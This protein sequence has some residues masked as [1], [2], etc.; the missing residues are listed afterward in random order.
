ML[1]LNKR[2]RYLEAEAYLLEVPKFTTKNTVEDTRHF[3]D[4]LGN[5]ENQ[6]KIIH[7]AGTNG[8]GSVCAYLCSVLGEAGYTVGMFSSPHLVEMRE[9]FRIGGEPVEERIFVDAFDQVMEKLRIIKEKNPYNKYYPTFFEFLF[10]MAMIIFREQ[11]VDYI[12]LETG[13][14]GRLDATNAIQNPALTVIT[15]IGLDHTEYLGNTIEEIAGEKA[16]ILKPGVPVVYCDKRNEASKVIEKRAKMLGNQVFS[17]GPKDYFDVIITNK[18]IAF[19]LHTRYYDYIRLT[20]ETK[21]LYQ[22]ENAALAVRCIEVLEGSR[23]TSAQIIRGIKKT[24]WEG[25]MEE[26]LPGVFADGA[27]N[28]DGI[29]AFLQ[30]VETDF[31]KGKQYLLFSVVAD[32]NYES[33]IRMI[34]EASLF[35]NIAVAALDNSRTA[36]VQEVYKLLEH[37]AGNQCCFFYN[38]E[39]ALKFLMKKKKEQDCIYIA[40]SLYLVGEIKALLRRRTDD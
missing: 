38:T 7:V 24:A 30:T 8:K 27:H 16:G 3:L 39:E 19:S 13:L 4:I 31:C 17:A 40:G 21:A 26:V 12:I 29:R 14:G 9:R 33:M 15:E 37:Y 22:V 6:K 36:D 10:F 20:V 23:I 25:R 1:L 34:G 2:S 11:K 28:E 5:P 18:N 32:K 35:D